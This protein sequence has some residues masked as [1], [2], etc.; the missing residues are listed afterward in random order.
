[1]SDPS[2]LPPNPPPAADRTPADHETSED[3]QRS[4]AELVKRS[5]ELRESGERLAEEVEH[6]RQ[7]SAAQKIAPPPPPPSEGT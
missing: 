5:Q 4:I 6:L 3:L 7:L 1:M 2:P